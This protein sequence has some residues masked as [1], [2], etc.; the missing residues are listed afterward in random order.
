MRVSHYAVVDK[1]CNDEFA[2][3]LSVIAQYR[4][5]RSKRAG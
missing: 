4:S 3:Q 1:Y 5:N 2:V